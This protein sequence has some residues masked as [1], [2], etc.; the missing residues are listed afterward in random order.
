MASFNFDSWLSGFLDIY[1]GYNIFEDCSGEQKS[2]G[3][4]PRAERNP[5]SE[6]RIGC[7]SLN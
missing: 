4:I 3:R 7:R 6:A 2:E 5:N 1:C